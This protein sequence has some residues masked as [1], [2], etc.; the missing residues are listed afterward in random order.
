[1]K[2]KVTA[3]RGRKLSEG[4]TGEKRDRLS[5]GGNSPASLRNRPVSAQKFY[6]LQLHVGNHEV[7]ARHERKSE[8]RHEKPS[9][10][11]RAGGTETSRRGGQS[12]RGYN[13]SGFV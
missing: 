5:A 10:R 11:P 8:R 13:A 6:K 7:P 1:M 4:P 9:E 3:S 12:N 2:K